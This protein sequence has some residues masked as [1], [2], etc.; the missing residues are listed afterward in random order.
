LGYIA[1][2]LSSFLIQ[3]ATFSLIVSQQLTDLSYSIIF[4]I[5]SIILFSWAGSIFFITKIYL[6]YDEILYLDDALNITTFIS[7]VR[8]EMRKNKRGIPFDWLI[9]FHGFPKKTDRINKLTTASRG[10]RLT[11]FVMIL[12][13]TGIMIE[14]LLLLIN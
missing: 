4:F 3:L 1:A 7:D 8:T 9:K 12:L 14:S 11:W 5:S 10:F 2:A 6:G 13:L